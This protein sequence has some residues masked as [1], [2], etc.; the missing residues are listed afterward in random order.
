[1]KVSDYLTE[2]AEV[3]VARALS[4]TFDHLAARHGRPSG[5]VGADTGF[6]VLG[7]G[8]LGGLELGYGSDLDL[9]F[10]HG[11]DSATRR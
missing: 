8:K 1:M 3:A 2:I 6:L 9:V 4:L 5:V 11:A 10:L 7:Y